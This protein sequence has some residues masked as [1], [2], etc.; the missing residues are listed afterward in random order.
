MWV[1]ASGGKPDGGQTEEVDAGEQEEEGWGLLDLGAYNKGWQVPWGG[2]DVVLGMS[3]W[4][5]SFVAVGLVVVPLV[6]RG[7]GFELGV[8]KLDQMA[9][10]E[11]TL[12]NQVGRHG[13]R[14]LSRALAQILR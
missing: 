14:S 10:A 9:Q 8:G 2:G 1:S 13:A 7:L 11:L 6:G 3:L 5:V 4:L 12:I